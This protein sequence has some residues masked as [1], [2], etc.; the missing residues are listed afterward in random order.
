MEKIS[1]PNILQV[2][3][4][5]VTE[6]STFYVTEVPQPTLLKHQSLLTNRHF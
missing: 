3:E 2:V 1:H 4:K 6:E 5:L